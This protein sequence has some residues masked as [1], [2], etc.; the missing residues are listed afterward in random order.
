[1]GAEPRTGR[2]EWYAAGRA[3]TLDDRTSPAR[4]ARRSGTR[5]LQRQHPRHRSAADVRRRDRGFCA[6][7]G[8]ALARTHRDRHATRRPRARVASGHPARRLRALHRAPRRG[9]RMT[10]WRATMAVTRWEFRRYIKWKQQIV[11][12]LITMVI[13]SAFVILPEL[14]DDDADQV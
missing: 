5:D 11:G 3:T 10:Y 8:R 14:G 9:A 13:V 12:M 1:P 2:A 4:H 6:P 7:R